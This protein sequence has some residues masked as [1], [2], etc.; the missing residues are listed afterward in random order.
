LQLADG[1]VDAAL[2]DS[3]PLR[4]ALNVRAGAIAHKGVAAAFSSLPSVI[5]P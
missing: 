4:R 1:G 3:V 2:R 5:A